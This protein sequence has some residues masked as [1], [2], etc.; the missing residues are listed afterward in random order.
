MAEKNYFELGDKNIS[1]GKY[2]K[3]VDC[4]CKVLGKN[5]ECVEAWDKLRSICEELDL[6]SHAKGICWL[7]K[8]INP[9]YDIVV[10]GF[11]SDKYSWMKMNHQRFS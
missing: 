1:E 7:I 5:P 3:S 6:F 11:V 2:A 4:F 10:D 9:E 8:E